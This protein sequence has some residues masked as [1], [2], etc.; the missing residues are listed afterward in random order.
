MSLAYSNA[1]LGH[2]VLWHESAGR[3]QNLLSKGGRFYQE[4]EDVRAWMSH[5]Q[6]LISKYE[7]SFNNHEI[8][9]GVRMHGH[10]YLVGG[11]AGILF[12]H[13]WVFLACQKVT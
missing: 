2:R 10:R 8:G 9:S 7:L 12:W 1:T 4:S 13:Y 3:L 11:W 5:T 6:R